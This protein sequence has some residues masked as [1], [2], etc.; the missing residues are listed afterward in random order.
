MDGKKS[1]TAEVNAFVSLGDRG[2]FLFLGIPL[3]SEGVVPLSGAGH[4]ALGGKV[5]KTPPKPLWFRTSS[6][7][8]GSCVASEGDKVFASGF[9][10]HK[11]SSVSSPAGP[12]LARHR[13]LSADAADVL[14]RS[15]A[16]LCSSPDIPNHRAPPHHELQTNSAATATKSVFLLVRGPAGALMRDESGTV[17]HMPKG[18]LFFRS[19]D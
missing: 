18:C 9:S 8:A 17:P 4:F 5:T 2:V 16:V 14:R 1:G 13:N 11:P 12:R 10:H 6:L 15:F 7:G 19:R 3:P